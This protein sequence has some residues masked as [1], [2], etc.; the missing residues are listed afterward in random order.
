MPKTI[1]ILTQTG[2]EHAYAVAEGL[3]RKG[4]EPLLWHTGD[5]PTCGSET[6]VFEEGR[7]QVKINGVDI[8]FPNSDETVDTVWR[9]RPT[10]VLRNTALHSADRKFAEV[11]CSVFRR[12]L[13]EVLSPGAFWVNPSTLAMRAESKPLQHYIAIKAGFR[14]PDTLYGNDPAEIR[15]F[16][17]RHGGRIVYKPFRGTSWRNEASTWVPYTA[18][19]TEE[20]LVGDEVLRA[21]PGIFQAL[22]PKAFELRVTVIGHQVFAAKILSQATTKGRLDWRKSYDELVIEEARLP[23]EVKDKCLRV[24]DLLGL[25]FGCFDIVV[26]PDEEY[27]FLE[28]NEMGQFLF[29]EHY[30]GLPLLDAFCE[31]LLQG[32]SDFE[33]NES[34]AKLRYADIE[35]YARQCSAQAATV[36][37][38]SPDDSSWEGASIAPSTE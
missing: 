15:R 34:T 8:N 36:H 10:F 19:L 31:F 9:R 18:T 13:L 25:V 3:R 35:E 22:V 11:E 5:F 16:L 17:R 20:N 26:T 1:L 33:W 7:R 2:D 29:V 6:L 38:Q 14:V 30:A 32:R 12:S 4:A 21:T 28:V 27:V 24:M 23:D 37:V